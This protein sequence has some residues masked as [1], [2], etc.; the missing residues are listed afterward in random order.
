MPHVVFP[1]THYS[2]FEEKGYNLK[3]FMDANLPRHRMFLCGVLP[4]WDTSW[5]GHYIMWSFGLTGEFLR[6]NDVCGIV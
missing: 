6:N 2:T 3:E 5:H 1:G 4:S